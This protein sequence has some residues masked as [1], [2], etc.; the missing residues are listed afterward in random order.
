MVGSKLDRSARSQSN[1]EWI[2]PIPFLDG[3]LVRAWLLKVAHVCHLVY[4]KGN[5][6]SVQ[7]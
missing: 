1:Q 7:K 5:A 2:F 3:L 4:L 6:L